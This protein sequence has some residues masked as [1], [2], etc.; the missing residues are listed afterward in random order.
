MLLIVSGNQACALEVVC[1]REARTPFIMLSKSNEDK[2]NVELL[3]STQVQGE[4][5]DLFRA[6][7]KF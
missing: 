3:D 1:G 6:Q 2:Y 5:G 7:E 4:L